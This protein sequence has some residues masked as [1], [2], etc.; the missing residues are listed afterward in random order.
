[1]TPVIRTFVR[2]VVLVVL[3]LNTSPERGYAQEARQREPLRVFYGVKLGVSAL[4]AGS[5]ITD[6]DFGT[7][8]RAVAGGAAVVLGLPASVVLYQ[9]YQ[10]DAQA[11]RRWRAISFGADLLLSAS[12][13]G[14]GTYLIARGNTDN[15]V[16]DQWAGLSAVSV[17]LFGGLL[18][19]LDRVAFRFER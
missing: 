10:R 1:M 3:I 9:S 13:V 8:E 12:L 19:A 17:G 2:F 7:V 5:A 16:S 4:L 15:N 14:Y 6:P 11:V 18:S